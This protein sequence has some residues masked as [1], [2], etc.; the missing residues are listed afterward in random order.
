VKEL[1]T[2]FINKKNFSNKEK[3]ADKPWVTKA[4][5]DVRDAALNDKE[6]QISRKF[7][8]SVILMIS[9]RVN[10]P[11]LRPN[12]RRD[13]YKKA[14]ARIQCRIRNLVDEFHKKTKKWACENYSTIFPNLRLRR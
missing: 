5:C 7:I 11:N 2:D 8:D 10:G 9:C 13:K 14:G 6:N 1:Q 4:P 3:F 12:I